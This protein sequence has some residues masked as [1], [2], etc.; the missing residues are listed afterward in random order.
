MTTDRDALTPRAEAD[1]VAAAFHEAMTLRGW[2]CDGSHSVGEG[3]CQNLAAIVAMDDNLQAV[4]LA[5]YSEPDITRAAPEPGLREAL[6]AALEHWLPQHS[7]SCAGQDEDAD[8]ICGT[9]EV[10]RAALAAS[11]PSEPEPL[12]RRR[13]FTVEDNPFRA[14]PEPGPTSPYTEREAHEAQ[15]T[16]GTHL[17]DPECP[18]C[19]FDH[20]DGE[21]RAALAAPIPS[22]PEPRE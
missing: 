2:K 19:F 18:F 12:K 7:S 11:V 14:A 16:A 5:E 3:H 22:E 4:L 1:E 9:S 17:F 6:A 21:A 15:S 13:G 20:F 10:Y 8:C